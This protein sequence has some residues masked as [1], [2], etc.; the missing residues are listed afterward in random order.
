MARDK[1]RET[2]DALQAFEDYWAMGDERSLPKLA[3]LY[4]NRKRTGQPVPTVQESALKRWS[5]SHGWQERC[6]QRITEEA[7][8]TREENRRAVARVRARTMKA[9]EADL[10]LYAQ[11]VAKG[12]AVLAQDAASLERM[13]KLYF[14]LAEEPLS[15]RYELRGPGPGG[16]HVVEHKGD[17]FD[18]LVSRLDSLAARRRE[19]GTPAEPDE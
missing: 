9:I 10:G 11:R 8:R 13:T 2:P 4:A 3:E 15:D 7:A 1:P 16:E 19:A 5:T 12:E 14:Q 17:A 6:K 18:E